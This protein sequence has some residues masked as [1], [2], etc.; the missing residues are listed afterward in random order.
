MAGL[1]LA[2]ILSVL[3][4]GAVTYLKKIK[5]PRAVSVIFIY[6]AI[7][8][9]FGSAFYFLV[10]PMVNEIKQF[11]ANL[12]GYLDSFS[13]QL[14]QVQFFW[15]T[16][17]T[18]DVLQKSLLG[19]GEKLISVTSNITS[20]ISTVFGG[21]F[22]ALVIFFVSLIL[23]LKENGTEEFLGI[24]VPQ[25]AKKDFVRIF[26]SSKRKIKYW[27]LGRFFSAVAVG[28]FI[29][30]G[31]LL[32]GVKYKITLALIAALFEFVPIL[33]AWFAGII[34]VVLTAFQSLKL[35]LFAGLLYLV[36]QQVESHIFSPFFMKKTVGMN[37]VLTIL[38]LMIG[39]E[40]GGFFGILIAVPFTAIIMEII[41]GLQ[42][43]RE[44]AN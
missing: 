32:M 38:A 27:F 20:L 42:K 34:G 29:Y 33:G 7:I 23:S 6:L 14:E 17:K 35:A 21:L 16:Y 36:V 10:P 26:S 18:S 37:P 44:E 25:S 24:F 13:P 1:F 31:L 3:V 9:I 30:L 19:I 4:D 5:I 15:N 2:L 12:P 22:T 11:S 39:A 40:L 41:N 28:V 43:T 8:F